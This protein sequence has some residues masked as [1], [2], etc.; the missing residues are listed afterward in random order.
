MQ[1]DRITH[2]KDI[3]IRNFRRWRAPFDPPTPKTPP[4]SRT[5]SSSDD[6]LRGNR[7]FFLEHAHF[8]HISTSGGSSGDGFQVAQCT[9]PFP[10]FIINS[11]YGSIWLSI[12]DMVM[13]QTG[14]RRQTN[15]SIA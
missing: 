15:D 7:R 9:A 10:I 4:K 2:S 14:D 6:P 3:F 12:R 1:V 13:G 5:W 8:R 11:H